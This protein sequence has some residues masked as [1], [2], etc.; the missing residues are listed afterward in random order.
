[1][2]NPFYDLYSHE[3][4]KGELLSKILL[5]EFEHITMQG[6]MYVITIPFSQPGYM[7]QRSCETPQFVTNQMNIR[8]LYSAKGHCYLRYS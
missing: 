7:N 1:M 8:G 5:Y 2:L 3:P 4:K 6:R